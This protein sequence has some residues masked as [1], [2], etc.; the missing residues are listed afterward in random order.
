M[1]SSRAVTQESVI[2]GTPLGRIEP[3]RPG[4]HSQDDKEIGAEVAST[5]RSPEL[6]Y[7]LLYVEDIGVCFIVA[8]KD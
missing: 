5:S 7:K 6:G 4:L 3:I 1:G 8:Q 2:Q